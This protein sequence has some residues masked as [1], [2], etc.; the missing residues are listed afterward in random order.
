M[1][2]RT[3]VLGAGECAVIPSTAT[4]VSIVTQGAGQLQSDC[5]NTPPV[6]AYQCW[7]F[8]WTTTTFDED[9]FFA[10][11]TVGTNTYDVPG[12][13]ND[14]DSL[15]MPIATWI[16]TD[17]QLN[18]IVELGCNDTNGIAPTE[19]VLKL[20]IP[21]GLGTPEFKIFFSDDDEVFAYLKGVLDD[22]C[23]DCS[24]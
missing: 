24:S 21:E 3:I 20:Q 8:V 17:P 15:S 13:Y 11:L 4:L 23:E 6:S 14:T 10:S 1:A 9:A 22:D 7:K 5:P 12:S 19:F 2:L 18:G 16:S